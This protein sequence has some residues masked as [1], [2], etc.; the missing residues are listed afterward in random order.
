MFDLCVAL[1][2][3]PETMEIWE[4]YYLDGEEADFIE[5]MRKYESVTPIKDVIDETKENE[6]KPKEKRDEELV[7]YNLEEV[8]DEKSIKKDKKNKKEKK[9]SKIKNILTNLMYFKNIIQTIDVDKTYIDNKTTVRQ[10]FKL[11]PQVKQIAIARP[12][13]K[14]E[15]A[16]AENI[17]MYMLDNKGS[18]LDDV[19]GKTINDFF[20][21]DTIT[22][23]RSVNNKN[24]KLELD[25]HAER[26]KLKT[27][28]RFKS[29][30]NPNLYLSVEPEK[31][32]DYAKV[33]AGRK[34]VERN[35]FVE[36]QLETRNVPMQTSMEIQ[37]IVA[38]NK[39]IYNIDNIDREVN[40]Y[41]EQG[42]DLKNIP[43][44]NADGQENEEEY[45]R[46]RKGPW[47]K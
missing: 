14:D 42:G 35:N 3:D 7:S 4:M 21:I 29:K 15:N 45:E 1:A 34:T 39:G 32:G 47:D 2:E 13:L 26:N 8:E 30:E 44:E 18:M 5:L 17:T 31:V 9:N 12:M 36:V 6:K 46:F 28:R 37:K 19:D 20:E 33:Y 24:T 16:L 10:G 40:E 11:P 23:R 43:I 41:E 38:E 25:G 22:E 27:I